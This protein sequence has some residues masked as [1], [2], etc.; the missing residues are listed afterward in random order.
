MSPTRKNSVPTRTARDRILLAADELFYRE[1]IRATGVDKLIAASGVA[2]L[3]FYRHFASKNDLV[4]AYLAGRH[5]LWI[6]WFVDALAR[7][8]PHTGA[9]WKALPP[10]MM[11]WFDQRTF[12]GCAFI[13]AAVELGAIL[14]EVAEA[15]REHKQA[16]TT[17]I[18]ALLPPSRQRRQQADTMA[19]AVDG[20]IV[21]A[22][23]GT[24]TTDAVRALERLLHALL[25]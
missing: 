11:E 24:Q 18:A 7:H 3:T 19:C 2:K 1:G 13:N 10:V 21:R 14:P 6:A 12:H 9:A 16:M 8:R 4:L 25:N 17:A 23:L 22:Q 5:E 15:C 20:A